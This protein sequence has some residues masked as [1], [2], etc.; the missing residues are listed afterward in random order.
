MPAR[1]TLTV[2]ALSDTDISLQDTTVTAQTAGIGIR[3]TT[4]NVAVDSIVT[5]DLILEAGGNIT[6]TGPVS[7]SLLT[8]SSGGSAV[9]SNTGNNI[10]SLGVISVSGPLTI[11]TDPGLTLTNT[12]TGSGSM[13][14]ESIGGDLTLDPSASITDTVRAAA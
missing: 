14:L 5:S 4:G 9:L 8:I 2:D 13:L 12:V 6:Q 1:E 10:S 7:A 3:A 11:Y